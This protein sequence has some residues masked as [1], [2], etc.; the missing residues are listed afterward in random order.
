MNSS[1]QI[2]SF[3]FS[4]TYG[5]IFFLLSKFNQYILVNKKY[6]VKLIVTF[7]FV[8][9]IVILYIYFMYL[10]NYGVIHPYFITMVILGFIIMGINY[11]KICKICVKKKKQV[12]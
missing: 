10:I 4:F 8:I 9:D 12:V 11:S 1:T 5:C 3:I 7:V 6:W 2:I